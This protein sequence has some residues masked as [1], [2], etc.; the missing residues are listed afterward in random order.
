MAKRQTECRTWKTY[1][2]MHKKVFDA[3]LYAIGESFSISQ[4]GRQTGRERS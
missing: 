2:I 3:E 4:R 1:M